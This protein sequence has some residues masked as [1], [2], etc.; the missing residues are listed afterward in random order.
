MTRASCRTC[1]AEAFAAEIP[2]ELHGWMRRMLEGTAP[3]CDRCSARAENEEQLR[4]RE[5]EKRERESLLRARRLASGIPARLRG[6]T[7]DDVSRGNRPEVL[8][9]ARSFA[10]GEMSGLLLGGPVGV[11]KTWLAAVAAWERLNC[12]SVRWFSVP[13]LFARLDLAFADEARRE[14]VG[15]L[16]GTGA[17]VLDDLDKVRATEYAAEQLFCAIDSRVTAGAQLLITTNLELGELA[18]R[19]PQPHGEAIVSRLVDYCEAFAL[20]GLNHRL[21]RF[22]S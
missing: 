15:V 18:A 11:G 13:V 7:W 20:D 14:A 3:L 21:E 4:E 19:F 10:A 22:A 17:L 12:R 2:A 8:A 9:A 6:L 1:G 16:A 5:R